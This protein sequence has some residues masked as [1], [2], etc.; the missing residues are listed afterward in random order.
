MEICFWRGF[1]IWGWGQISNVEIWGEG[2]RGG[3]VFF[4]NKLL[5]KNFRG[6]DWKKWENSI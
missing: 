4:G 2:G 5:G 6:G 3:V 1:K